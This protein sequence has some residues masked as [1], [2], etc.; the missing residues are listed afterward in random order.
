MEEGRKEE[1]KVYFLLVEYNKFK[2]GRK[3]F[4]CG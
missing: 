4:F 2:E 1:Y 3:E